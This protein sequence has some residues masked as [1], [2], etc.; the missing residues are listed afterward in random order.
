RIFEATEYISLTRWA[1]CVN[2]DMDWDYV[3]GVTEMRFRDHRIRWVDRGRGAWVNG[4]MQSM[5]GPARQAEGDFWIPM[6]LLDVLVDPLWEGDLTWDSQQRIMR[7][8]SGRRMVTGNVP[9]GA[10]RGPRV[11]VLDPGHGGDD[12]GCLHSGGFREKD[13]VLKIAGHL[14]EHLTNRLGARV[15]LT[16]PGDYPVPVDERTAVANRNRADLF[17]SLHVAPAE[18]MPGKSFMVY[19]LPETLPDPVTGDLVRWDDRSEQVI[20]DTGSFARQFAE[21]ASVSASNAGYGIQIMDLRGLKGLAMP[22]FLIELSW[23]SSFYGD[24]GLDREGGLNRASEAL[25]DGIRSIYAEE[26]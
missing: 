5:E 7:R 4:R 13:V 11:I 19:T 24:V 10:D 20:R 14:A 18:E 22:A 21:A 9:E 16:R 2:A 25:F 23:E 15:I 3:T 8:L 1:L 26:N 12:A 17:I 6:S